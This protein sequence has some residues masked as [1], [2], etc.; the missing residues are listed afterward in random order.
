MARLLRVLDY[1]RAIQS[2]NLSQIIESN[3][4]LLI[5]VEQAAQLT[6]T[7]HLKQR[8]QVDKV[9]SNTYLF[10][11]ASTYKGNNL[12]EYTEP[13]FSATTVYVTNE[14]ISF[15]GNIY[16]SIAGSVAHAFNPL[17]WNKICVDKLLYYV[18]LPNPSYNNSISY[19][20]GDVV[21]YND[22]TY[23][24]LQPVSGI[25]PTNTNYWLVGASYSVTGILPTDITSWTLGD[26]RNQE[27]VQYLID[28]TLYNLHCR[29]NPRNV[30]ELRKERY[31]GNIASQIGG[32][33]GWLKNVSA[34]KVYVDIPE[35][36]PTQGNS[37]TWGNANGSS[38]ASINMY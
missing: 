31:D 15:S 14:R 28:I 13:A 1:E 21:F 37:I 9:F 30:P 35:I 25:L 19:A 29:I 3:Y 4:N 16:E 12:V 6:M 34:G 26:N 27:I 5:D 2:D 23:T 32:A 7:G 8:Y 17:E 18:T 33:I 36:L 22:Y 11:V 38:V 20:I 10:N 24:C